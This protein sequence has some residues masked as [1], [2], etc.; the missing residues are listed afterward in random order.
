[1]KLWAGLLALVRKEV[2][3]L[4]RD[5]H[6]LAVLFI[7][8]TLFLLLMAG[9]MSSYMQD[10]PPALR[11]IIEAPQDDASQ[12]F[13]DALQAQLA[14]STLL[15][16]SDERLA[17][18]RLPADF[19]DTLL[20][21]PHQ[22]PSLSY[23]AQFDKL[24]RQRL[25]SA[26]SIALAQTR[27]LTYLED[28]GVVD[29]ELSRAERLKLVQQRTQSQINEQE[30]LASGDLSG[31]ANAT[32]LS[33][34]AWLIFGMFF[35]V[36]PMAGGF[37]R[38]QQS[39]TLLRLRCLGLNLGTLVLSKLLPYFAINLLQFA[40]LLSIGV[41]GLPLLGLPALSLPGSAVAYPLLA[42]SVALATCSLGLL[43]AALAR[44]SEQALLLGGGINILLAAIGGIM[45]PKSVMPAAMAQLAEIS[46][47]SWALDAFLT[48]LV[49][50]G[51]LADIAPYCARLLLFAAVC[52]MAG[53]LLFTRRVQRTQW[54]TH[55]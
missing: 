35:V 13:R 14:D 8:P 33:V 44:S 36:L 39:G 45:V 37:Q 16:N 38:E 47:M 40:L 3:L 26:V 32:Q 25:H 49:G 34:P 15:T 17:R 23:P 46:P 30:Q 53:L 24:S 19:T 5:P 20:D 27:L 7:M 10:K 41:Y 12:F 1:M 22:G 42:I 31:R 18:V 54:T 52:G 11:V 29:A 6:A 28:S 43:L 55:Y 9:A 50:H 2:L 4:L 51:S 21:S 48:L